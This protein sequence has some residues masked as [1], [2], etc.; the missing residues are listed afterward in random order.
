MVIKNK[1]S[2]HRIIR[3]GQCRLLIP[4][5]PE[6]YQ[7]I[8]NDLK[9]IYYKNEG[10]LN[11]SLRGSVEAAAH[12]GSWSCLEFF[13]ARLQL[14]LLP[15]IHTTTFKLCMLLDTSFLEMKRQLCSGVAEI[16]NTP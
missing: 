5:R 1:S 14:S 9:Q 11:H 4:C 7:Y 3:T 2:P 12:Q 13:Q 8:K 16:F 6:L 15:H 10:L